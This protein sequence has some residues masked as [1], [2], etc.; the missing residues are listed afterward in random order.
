MQDIDHKA[1]VIIE[2]LKHYHAQLSNDVGPVGNIFMILAHV[3]AVHF[4]GIL[5]QR[6]ALEFYSD[7]A[8]FPCVNK[9]YALAPYQL[10]PADFRVG[11]IH[12][13]LKNRVRRMALSRTALGEALPFGFRQNWIIAK[14][15]NLFGSYKPFARAYLPRQQEQIELLRELIVH[16][17]SVLEIPGRDVIWHNWQQFV[18]LHTT[19]KH[20]ILH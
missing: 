12:N 10:S 6:E 4:S 8:I 13:N 14:W 7:R 2:Q 3:L 11:E 15:I 16:L 17:C 9:Q 20:P 5:I 1:L 18:A 19:D